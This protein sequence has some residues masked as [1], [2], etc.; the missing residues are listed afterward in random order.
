MELFLREPGIKEYRYW[1][2]CVEELKK[3]RTL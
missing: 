2:D 3:G 1:I